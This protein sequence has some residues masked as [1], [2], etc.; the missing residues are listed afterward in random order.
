MG[1][2]LCSPFRLQSDCTRPSLSRLAKSSRASPLQDRTV[3]D[4]PVSSLRLDMTALA[5]IFLF[6]FLAL[7]FVAAPALAQNSDG[8]G[9]GSDVTGSDVAGALSQSGIEGAEF[10][11]PAVQQ[12]VNSVAAALQQRLSTGM[13]LSSNEPVAT[14]AT[15][16]VLADLLVKVDETAARG[17]FVNELVAAGLDAASA[18][19]LADAVAG[20]LS[21]SSVEAASLVNAVSAYNTAVDAAPA[22]FLNAPTASFEGVRSVL[23]QLMTAS[24]DR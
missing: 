14:G 12:R 19:G 1:R 11:S 4:P 15:S 16:S 8:G 13:L 24:E 18:Q 10:A 6:A 22:S 5:R 2:T 23:T 3:V 9:S 7:A 21:G 17:A 20:L